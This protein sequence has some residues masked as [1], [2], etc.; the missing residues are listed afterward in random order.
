MVNP[1]KTNITVFTRKYIPEPIEPPKLE[2]KG[3]CFPHPK[4]N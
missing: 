4:L 1:S 2:G 3:E